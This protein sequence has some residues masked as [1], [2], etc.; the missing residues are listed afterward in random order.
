MCH[1]PAM[2]LRSPARPSTCHMDSDVYTMPFCDD[3]EGGDTGPQRFL[4]GGMDGDS[5]LGPAFLPRG[6]RT[7][8]WIM[9]RWQSQQIR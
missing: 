7:C 6:F 5:D 4:L 9:M 8:S 3:G 2:P 1:P